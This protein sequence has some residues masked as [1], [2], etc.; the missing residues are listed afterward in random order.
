[1]A[2]YGQGLWDEKTKHPKQLK[3]LVNVT[4]WYLQKAL[5]DLKKSN[6]VTGRMLQS[7][8]LLMNK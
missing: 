8:I 2:G 3:F 1:M 6:Y 4:E 7:G 5:I